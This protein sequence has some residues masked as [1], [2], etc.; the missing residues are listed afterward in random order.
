MRLV[1]HPDKRL[2]QAAEPVDFDALPDGE[3]ARIVVGMLDTM[4]ANDGIGLAAPQVGV[5]WRIIIVDPI[6]QR[7]QAKVMVNPEVW[8]ESE[9]QV[10]G[11]EGCLSVPG[12]WGMVKRPKSIKV[13]YFGTD[14][15]ARE[16]EAD[17]LLARVIQHEV[18]HLDGT[19]FIEKLTK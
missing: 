7:H 17:D 16:L 6:G 4:Y 13:R 11:P 3:L 8:W 1:V 19:L 12:T 10:Q 9:E 15:L 14:G 18:D 2:K 5:S